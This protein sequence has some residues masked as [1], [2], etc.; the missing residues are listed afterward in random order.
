M[1]S[2]NNTH[3]YCNNPLNSYSF[4]YMKVKI[5][6]S[7]LNVI[8]LYVI[9]FV[10]YL[11]INFMTS[12]LSYI[13]QS[14]DYY[15]IDEKVVG[16]VLGT[17]SF[18]S[19]IAVIISDFGIGL[20]MDLMG[21]KYPIII[22]L[23]IS[24][25][26]IVV[27]P[28]GTQIYPYLC[29]FKVLV[30]VG[31]LPAMNSPLIPDYIEKRSQGL[32]N[33][34]SNI[35]ITFATIIS[36][37]LVIQLQFVMDLKYC[38]LLIGCI[39]LVSVP[40]LLIGIKDLKYQKTISQNTNHHMTVDQSDII[41]VNNNN[42]NN[43]K[44]T[45][46]QTMNL[47]F[48]QLYQALRYQPEYIIAILIGLSS[49]MASIC[50]YQ[51]GPIYFKFILKSLG[52]S[53]DYADDAVSWLMLVSNVLVIPTALIL[54]ILSDKFKIWKLMLAV[55]VLLIIFE[56]IFIIPKGN[57]VTLFIG[58]IGALTAQIDAYLLSIT[59]LSKIVSKESR[60]TLFGAFSLV[61][62]IGVLFINKMGGH[63]YSNVDKLWPFIIILISFSLNFVIVIVL[64][65]LG[66]LRV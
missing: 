53:Q 18:Y 23:F 30:A 62:S 9:Q 15:N 26:S 58:F 22:G 59:M 14:N 5:E 1:I 35:V 3:F 63:L 29:I 21:R 28:Y 45:W 36:T 65:M 25:I 24:G 55:I 6:V 50:F 7:K 4:M 8:S 64:A 17:L 2:H 19:E 11:I 60:G 13:I 32:A 10:T 16:N 44:K 56:L 37:S 33:S 42:N 46:R 61:G 34:Y 43:T 38:F 48:T 47:A 31:V 66:K 54:G 27:I 52:E 12:F 51:F 57:E 39:V 40:L 20:L 49:K 41:T